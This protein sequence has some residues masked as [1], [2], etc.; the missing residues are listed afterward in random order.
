M[1]K[2][3]VDPMESGCS[4]QVEVDG[5]AILRIVYCPM[6]LLCGEM[7][8]VIKSI[9]VETVNAGAL[10]GLKNVLARTGKFEA[11]LPKVDGPGNPAWLQK[12]A[13]EQA[14][15]KGETE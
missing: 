12:Q 6:H 1:S 5:T 13:A 10:V 11:S 2:A 8:S 4:C 9:D 15:Q 3:A 14:A 7:L